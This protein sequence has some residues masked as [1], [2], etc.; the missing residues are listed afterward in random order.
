MAREVEEG[1]S[2]PGE[3][4]DPLGIEEEVVATERPANTVRFLPMTGTGNRPQ[5]R[6]SI[7]SSNW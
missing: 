2:H 7:A 4:G 6:R 3:T 5:G 1:E